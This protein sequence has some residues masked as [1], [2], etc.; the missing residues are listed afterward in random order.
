MSVSYTATGNSRKLTP[1]GSI[2]WPLF[3]AYTLNVFVTTGGLAIGM[4]TQG[5]ISWSA[6]VIALFS[7]IAFV[8]TLYSSEIGR[9]HV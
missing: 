7:V 1:S 3:A 6:Y 4:M 8:L 5:L 2:R 9:A